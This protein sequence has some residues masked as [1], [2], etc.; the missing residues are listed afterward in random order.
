MKKAKRMALSDCRRG[1]IVR[2]K[3]DTVLLTVGQALPKSGL[4]YVK[5]ANGE[6]FWR[7]GKDEV[8]IEQI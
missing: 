7:D 3:P 4:V 5:L 1:A 8:F 2:M 6:G